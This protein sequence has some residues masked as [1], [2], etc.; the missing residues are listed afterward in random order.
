M[1]IIELKQPFKV[2]G[3]YLKAM[4]KIWK[5]TFILENLPNPSQEQNSQT[6]KSVAL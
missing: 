1:K 5:I 3:N 2:S 6:L 4:H